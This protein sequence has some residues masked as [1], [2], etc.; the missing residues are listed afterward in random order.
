[1]YEEKEMQSKCK[2]KGEFLYFIAY[3]GGVL[4]KLYSTMVAFY[5]GF[6]IFAVTYAVLPLCITRFFR[7]YSCGDGN[8]RRYGN[9]SL[10]GVDRGCGAKAC[11]MRQ[12][13]CVF[14]YEF[15]C[16]KNSRR[17]QTTANQRDFVGDFTCAGVIYRGDVACGGTSFGIVEK[18]LWNIPAFFVGCG[19]TKRIARK[20]LTNARFRGRI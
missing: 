14:A 9:H 4:R 12:F 2:I 10:I 8:G 11:S 16:S 15:V 13:V 19:L 5:I 1:M 18:S 20:G 7:R 6:H 17:Q 3:M